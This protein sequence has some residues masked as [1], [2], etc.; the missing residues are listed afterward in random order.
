VQRL[1]VSNDEGETGA[2]AIVMVFFF[3]S[4]SNRL[5]LPIFFSF[6]LW[7]RNF[8]SP[9]LWRQ[10]AARLYMG[11]RTHARHTLGYTSHMKAVLCTVN[12][13]TGCR[14]ECPVFV[15]GGA[16][17]AGESGLSFDRGSASDYIL[18]IGDDASFWIK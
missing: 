14:V 9:K 15:H 5:E 4:S 2:L 3:S 12:G 17:R 10:V 16:V 1:V 13:L 8:S 18:P 6:G 7:G 11:K